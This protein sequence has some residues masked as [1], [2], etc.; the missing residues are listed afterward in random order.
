MSADPARESVVR[1]YATGVSAKQL[2]AQCFTTPQTI[3]RWVSQAG[4]PVRPR[5]RPVEVRIDEE[6][7]AQAVARYLDG[8]SIATLARDLGIPPTTLSRWI[9]RQGVRRRRFRHR[10]S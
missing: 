4:I 2:A 6:T 5:G 3:L 1:Q 9:D 7:G 10:S 8:V